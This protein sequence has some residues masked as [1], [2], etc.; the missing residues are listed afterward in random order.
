LANG[1]FPEA[2]APLAPNFIPAIPTDPIDGKPLRY[3]RLPDGGILLYSIG[4]DQKDEGGTVV[5]DKH[6]ESSPDLNQ[7]DWV[8]QLRAEKSSS[9]E[10]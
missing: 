3:R 1:K 9:P 4:W 5:W 2:L 8:W 7:G 6:K 10:T